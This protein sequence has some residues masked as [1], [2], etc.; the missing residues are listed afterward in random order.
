MDNFLIVVD[1]HI[2]INLAFTFSSLICLFYVISFYFSYCFL[3]YLCDF[4]YKLINFAP[5][6]MIVDKCIMR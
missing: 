3:H 1:N 6:L 2:I 5:C 4:L